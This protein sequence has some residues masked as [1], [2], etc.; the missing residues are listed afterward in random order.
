[1]NVVRMNEYFLTL[2]RRGVSS[3][4]GPTKSAMDLR[5]F[6]NGTAHMTALE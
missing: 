4:N 6:I 1:M 5:A 2:M 3:M